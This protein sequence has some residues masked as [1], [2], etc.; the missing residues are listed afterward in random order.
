MAGVSM[1]IS[2][3]DKFSSVLDKFEDSINSTEKIVQKMDGTAD[4]LGGTL[5]G[6]AKQSFGLGDALQKLYFGFGLIQQIAPIVKNAIS[7]ASAEMRSLAEFGEQGGKAFNAFVN[8]AANKLGRAASD[9]NEA[10]RLWHKN[11]AGGRDIERLTQVA[12][13][14]A[15]FGD[16]N[17]FKDV[18]NVLNDAIKTKNIGGLAGL[19][20]GGARVEQ[21][22]KRAGMERA[23]RRGDV[24]GAMDIYEKIADSLGMTSE[25]AAAFGDTLENKIKKTVNVLRNWFGQLLA[26]IGSKLKPIVDDIAAAVSSDKVQGAMRR[27]LSSVSVLG[28]KAVWLYQTIKR[29]VSANR[30]FLEMAL[31]VG[32]ITAAVWGCVKAFGVLNLVMRMNP[33][34]AAIGVVIAGLT[35]IKRAIESATNTT[36][37]AID[38]IIGIVVGGVVQIVSS[39]ADA[40]IAI[41]NAIK[42][43]GEKVANGFIAWGEAIYNAA[44]FLWHGI[45]SVAIRAFEFIKQ[46][47][48]AFA[49]DVLDTIA[50]LLESAK[51][52]PF[53][54]A[55]GLD[56]AIEKVKEFQNTLNGIA[57][58][59]PSSKIEPFKVERLGRV[60]LDSTEYI[61]ADWSAK[62]IGAAIGLKNKLFDKVGGAFDAGKQDDAF[63]SLAGIE[64]NTGKILGEMTKEQDL[65]WLKELAE[66]EFVN[67]VNVRT[68]T[69]TVNIQT[70]NANLKPQ[71]VAR[72]LTKALETMQAASAYGAHGGY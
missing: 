30:D 57:S 58:E 4:R 61:G 16:S 5:Q 49:A 60:A 54:D 72:E 44:R 8:T 59:N 6:A 14:F 24:Q 45:K 46:K 25:K 15:K 28:D 13:K 29:F 42:W 39:V 17:S 20:G 19:L 18:A 64:R 36:V 52:V 1:N 71:D 43:T 23:L 12:D 67:N 22:L 2:I 37:S 55:L 10:G 69:P 38:F 40:G 51:K 7:A 9:L 53:A 70:H 31:T 48:S 33:I 56:T 35:L 3:V 47:L 62:A 27:V 21:K 34:I 65:R 68:L 32:G 26:I 41:W 63:D 66:R 50:G 11:G